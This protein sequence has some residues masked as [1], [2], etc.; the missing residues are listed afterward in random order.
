MYGKKTY[1]F[2][3]AIEVQ[4]YHSAR[5]GAP[6]QER[7]KKKKPTPEQVEKVNQANKER[8]ARHRLRLYFDTGDY[9]SCLT[10]G[11]DC[12]PPDMEAA[13]EDFRK[14]LKTVRREYRKRGAPVYWMRNIEVGTK[15]GWHI[16]M[17]VN[18]IPDTDVILAK[19][20]PHGRGSNQLTHEK[21]EFR[22]LAAYLTKT[23]KTDP[24]LREAN[25]DTSRNMPLPE[26]KKKIYRRWRTWKEIR[27]PKGFYLDK[28]SVHEGINAVTGYPY[29]EYTL[30]RIKRRPLEKRGGS[31]RRGKS[32]P[33]YRDQR[34]RPGPEGREM[35]VCS[36][37]H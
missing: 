21:G 19:A 7:M 2:L 18:R 32:K 3:N 30:L 31:R 8:R 33:I 6:G 35:R 17:V 20:W 4:E 26:P 12:R 24:R 14:F 28:E 37:V 27:V 29:R 9:F 23:P 11:R 5:Y 10:Y 34:S 25:F 36:R 16:H 22:E 1:E 13:K 15:G